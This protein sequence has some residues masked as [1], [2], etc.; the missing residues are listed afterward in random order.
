MSGS[1]HLIYFMRNCCSW[2]SNHI[3]NSLIFNFK[4]FFALFIF[5][6]VGAL[7]INILNLMM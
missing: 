2:V 3:F 7:L 1:L 4:N 6:A 5:L